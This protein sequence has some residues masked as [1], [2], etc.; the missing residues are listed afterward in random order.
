MKKKDQLKPIT[1]MSE[2]D[3][4]NIEQEIH[5]SVR[6][7]VAEEILT[8]FIDGSNEENKDID[9]LNQN[10]DQDL[11][12]QSVSSH[13]IRIVIWNSCSDCVTNRNSSKVDTWEN[14][15]YSG[16]H[17]AF[18]TTVHTEVKTSIF[19]NERF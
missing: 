1:R 19:A 6:R 14:I 7:I 4:Q 16:V 13:L 5:E 11:I 10:I 2:Q 8:K 15:A 17:S 18:Q 12:L 3:F 9:N